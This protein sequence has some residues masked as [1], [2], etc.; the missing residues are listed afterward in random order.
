MGSKQSSLADKSAS[1][2]AMEE[3]QKLKQ[4]LSGERGLNEIQN[5]KIMAESMQ[6]V[7]ETDS[8]NEMSDDET[9][10][11]GMFECSLKRN[12]IFQA[13][14]KNHNIKINR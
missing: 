8:E 9:D 1:N 7:I 5:K 6:D 4:K 2:K 12:A 3:T 11:E 14:L 10:I 13:L